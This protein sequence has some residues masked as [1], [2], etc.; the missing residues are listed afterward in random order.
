MVEGLD[1]SHHNVD[2]PKGPINWD[3]VPEKYRWVAIKCSEGAGF[4]DQ[5]FGQNFE[6]AKLTGRR[7]IAYHYHRGNAGVAFQK[8]NW[9]AAL[10]GREIDG[11]A[12]DVESQDSVTVQVLRNRVYWSLRAMEELEVPVIVYTADWFWSS[13]LNRHILPLNP[14]NSDDPEVDPKIIASGWD[15][16]VAHWRLVNE[17]R[18]PDQDDFDAGFPELPHGWR[19]RSGE[20]ERDW[21]IWQYTSRGNV[22]GIVGNVDKNIMRDEYFELLGGEVEPPPPPNGDH[23]VRLSALEDRA[24]QVDSWGDSYPV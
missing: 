11:I 14:P 24:D 15:L 23:E 17:D 7:V 4:I 20:I 18:L 16:W 22:P 3:D 9:L 19:R 5:R 6:G 12:L 13:P 8:A 10:G 21:S 1:I 2:P